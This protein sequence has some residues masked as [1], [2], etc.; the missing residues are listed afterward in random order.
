MIGRISAIIDYSFCRRYP[1]KS[2]GCAV[3]IPINNQD[4]HRNWYK[5]IQIRIVIGK[6]KY[7]IDQDNNPIIMVP[8]VPFWCTRREMSRTINI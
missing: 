4:L 3:K 6:C 2:H 8:V 1:I 7:P 5:V